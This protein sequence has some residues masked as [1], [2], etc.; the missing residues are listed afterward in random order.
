MTCKI[1][2]LVNTLSNKVHKRSS[3]S[4]TRLPASSPS[5]LQAFPWNSLC[6]ILHKPLQEPATTTLHALDKRLCHDSRPS[7]TRMRMI[8]RKQRIR[9]VRSQNLPDARRIRTMIHI[10]GIRTQRLRHSLCIPHKPASIRVHKRARLPGI[11]RRLAAYNDFCAFCDE[12]FARLREVVGECVHGHL[13]AVEGRGAGFVSRARAHCAPVVGAGVEG[14]AVV[15]AEFH[16]YYVVWLDEGDDFVEAAF[17]GEGARRPAANG[18]VDDGKTDG[19]G[20]EDAP[21]W[22]LLDFLEGKGWE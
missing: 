18:F 17:D 13:L 20:E 12:R 15:V 9:L 4:L 11:V 21:A 6:S 14:S 1:K 5:N 7:R 10:H 22:G 2:F 3:S 19:V 16:D 8:L